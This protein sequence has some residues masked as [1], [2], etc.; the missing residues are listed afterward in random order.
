MGGRSKSSQSTSNQQTTNNIV[1][2]GDYAGVG[3]NVTHD[4]SSTDNSINDSYNTDNSQEWDVEIDNSISNDG[5]F[6]G[7]NGSI[8]VLDGGVIDKAF[9]FAGGVTSDALGFGEKALDS[10]ESVSNAAIDAAKDAAKIAA[11]TA[12]DAIRENGRVIDSSLKLADNAINEV[13]SASKYAIDA[14]NDNAQN[15]VDEI[16]DLSKKT[17]TEFS[18]FSLDAVSEL[19][20]SLQ[21]TTQTQLNNSAQSVAQLAQSY[22]ED[23][24][25]I[26]ELARNTALQ[27]QD[28]VANQAGE[29]VKYMAM[30]LGVVGLA[31]VAFSITRGRNA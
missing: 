17:V 23:K 10:N 20:S 28:I 22:S 3:G 21:N 13:G 5:D 27:G 11:E 2:D 1:N 30:A 8:N 29:M 26:A 12:A 6:A 19:S 9:D 4:E 31:V 25:T 15:S 24:S 18:E 16:S 14:V 7:N